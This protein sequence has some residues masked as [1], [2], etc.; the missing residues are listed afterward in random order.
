MAF[1]GYLDSADEFSMNGWAHTDTL[2]NRSVF[3]DILINRRRVCTLLAN[4]YRS[5]VEAAGYG[6]GRKGFWLNPSEHLTVSENL[7]EV[8]ITGTDQLLCGGRQTIRK[9][10]GQRK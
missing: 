5:D 9:S 2:P 7:V 4:S 6:N 3:V 10:L 1:S 8:F